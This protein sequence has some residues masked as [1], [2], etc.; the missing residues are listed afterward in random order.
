MEM[1]GELERIR[2]QAVGIEVEQELLELFQ[3]GKEEVCEIP[4]REGMTQVFV[5]Y[6]KE[7]RD[8]Y[9]VFINLH[10]GG[11]VKGHREQDVVFCRNICQNMGCMVYDI[12]YKT[13]PEK[14]YPYALHEVY[15]VIKYLWNH[16]KEYHL[17]QAAF[18][19]A[20]HSAGGNL[21]LGAA[22]MAGRQKEFRLA[23]LICDYPP[24]DLYK[25]PAKKRFADDPTVRPPIA[26]AR[27]YNDWY[28][29]PDR[30]RESTASP[31][32]AMDEELAVLPPVL[33]I[34]AG[35]DV[36]G[37]EAEHLAYRMI[38]AGTTVLAKRVI[39]ADHGFVVRRKPG[40]EQAEKL[41]F[42]FL[43]YLYSSQ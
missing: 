30:R 10:G 35:H 5:Y 23:G 34:T 15:D 25:D 17:D 13:A 3:A 33:L 4:T 39:G 26:D 32:F 16:A 12:D 31:V 7:E 2:T 27:M 43:R 21:T 9:P 14:K 28:I 36:L 37:E 19:T 42:A 18:V 38:E 41:I 22:L 20:G 40:F 8:K 24:V 6:P 1:T 11:F 29:D